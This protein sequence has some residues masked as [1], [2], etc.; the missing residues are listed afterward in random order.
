MRTI[1]ILL[2]FLITANGLAQVPYV[3]AATNSPT[4]GYVLTR[5]GGTGGNNKWSVAG[6]GGSFLT[7][8]VT[9]NTSAGVTNL[10]Q[11]AGFWVT[12]PA[13]AG[14]I[15]NR[16]VGDV[17]IGTSATIDAGAGSV[18]SLGKGS[19]SPTPDISPFNVGGMLITP[20]ADGNNGLFTYNHTAGSAP[21]PFTAGWD[22]RPGGFADA[23][24]PG[25]SLVGLWTYWQNNKLEN[26]ATYTAWMDSLSGS[27]GG[28]RDLPA[29]GSEVWSNQRKPYFVI[30]ASNTN[31]SQTTMSNTIASFYSHGFGVLTN[32]GVPLAYDLE[33]YWLTNHRS[34]TYPLNYLAWNT[35][36]WP[37]A[38]SNPTNL[39]WY[40]RTNQFETWLMMYA[41]TIVPT[42]NN[43]EMDIDA[44]TATTFWEYP[45]GVNGIPVNGLMQPMMT[46]NTIH[47]DV[48]K[49]YQWDVGGIILQDSAPRSG[50]PGALEQVMNTFTKAIQ[51]PNPSSYPSTATEGYWAS[52]YP[53][54]MNMH[55]MIVGYLYQPASL[56]F[57]ISMEYS[58]NGAAV[59]TGN[60]PVEPG[61]TG[62]LRQM[63]SIMRPCMYSLTNWMPKTVYWILNADALLYTG[64]DYA[65][66]KAF[67]SCVAM[68]TANEWVRSWDGGVLTN[69]SFL[70]LTTNTGY[71]NIWQDPAQN[72]LK[73]INFGATN[74]IVSK[75]LYNGD[76]AV[77]FIN[78]DPA[79]ATNLTVNWN[80]LNISSN[81]P[82][83]VTEVWTNSLLGS[84][85]NSFTVSVPA[86]SSTVIKFSPVIGSGLSNYVQTA[87]ASAVGPGT[88]NQLAM[89]T[90]VSNV[91][92]SIL[93]QVSTNMIEQRSGISG[94]MTNANTN[95]IYGRVTSATDVEA[96]ELVGAGGLNGVSK[97]HTVQG[98]ASTAG[99]TALYVQDSWGIEPITP[100]S[101]HSAGNIYPLADDAY[102]IGST[103][104]KVRGF[105][106]GTS[107]Y[108]AIVNT[109]SPNFGTGAS[110]YGLYMHAAGIDIGNG[111]GQVIT[112]ATNIGTAV[113]GQGSD[114]GNG[115]IV[116][117]ASLSHPDVFIHRPQLLRALA[118]T[119]NNNS[120]SK[121]TGAL[122]VGSASDDN[123][124]NRAGGDLTLAGG[125]A[126]GNGTN[127][128]ISLGTFMQGASGFAYNNVQTNRLTIHSHPITLTTNAAT[129][130]ASFTVPTSLTVVG[131]KFSATTE[132]K[133]ATDI[134]TLTEEFRISS[135]NKAGTVTATNSAPIAATIA[136]GAATIANT[137]TVSVSSTTVSI[138][139]KCVT[140]GIQATTS[141]LVGARIELDSDSFSIVNWAP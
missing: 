131:A 81:Y 136:T 32:L 111:V 139:C 63:V 35:N 75:T 27:V 33:N 103:S 11:T 28:A 125:P 119:T 65:D 73:V 8:V 45:N 36:A 53:N 21:Y 67:L 108:V 133:D 61:S 39:T 87:V 107:G 99:T 13:T 56:P 60:F 10:I 44:F 120:T 58:A 132:I 23:G 122:V 7:N 126:S 138:N 68:T 5:S 64:W 42:A 82:A 89:F 54:R 34:G 109:A 48:T 114:Y 3:S 141:R 88:I 1:L 101:G 128:D 9:T 113:S 55:G 31:L 95:R 17:R 140:G 71:I 50:V 134:A 77:W 4:D 12:N 47:K 135:V 46:V 98:S 40:L 86:A 123:A 104:A 96:L 37:L 29:H 117:G 102:T 74:Q 121:A 83:V 16:F 94:S 76:V 38:T 127:G 100:Q 2:S 130:V 41:D 137:W 78:E 93:D 51:Y 72:R 129:F 19:F 70:T 24:S 84:Y 57:P 97:L 59:E 118:V 52:F 110:G 106:A 92:N 85:T 14:S 124:V 69:T 62:L 80:Q 22:S 112:L 25:Q 15:S 79:V 90:S 18:M 6:G 115:T 26:G 43:T 49:L 66:C 116:F 105:T 30:V 91:G 20:S